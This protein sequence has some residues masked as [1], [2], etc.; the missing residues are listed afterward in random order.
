[1]VSQVNRPKEINSNI[2]NILI[3]FDIEK[4]GM[5][6]IVDRGNRVVF[7]ESGS[8]CKQTPAT[9]FEHTC[10]ILGFQEGSSRNYIR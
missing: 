5:L 4:H 2:E 10:E 8:G 3:F 6:I 7:Y 1:M 9:V